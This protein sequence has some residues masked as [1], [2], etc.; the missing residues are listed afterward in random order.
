MG[1]CIAL[2]GGGAIRKSELIGVAEVCRLLGLSPSTV[3]NMDREGILPA[4]RF[5][6][7]Y[8]KWARKDVMA[9]ATGEESEDCERVVIIYCRVSHARQ[10]QLKESKN[11]DVSSDL[12]RQVERMKHEA[13]NRYPGL[14]Q[15]VLAEQGSGMNYER[16][17][18]NKFLDEV[19][20][21]KW[22]NSICLVENRERLV[23]F[24]APLVSKILS[25]KGIEL[26][27]T[28]QE[29]NTADQDFS[30]DI[31]ACIHY[32][33]TKYYSGRANAR[34][35]AHLSE[36]VIRIAKQRIELGIAVK[37]VA[38][39][40][41]LEGF[42][43]ESGGLLSYNILNKY[44]YQQMKQLSKTI[45]S[46]ESSAKVYKREFI[47]ETTGDYVLPVHRVY[48]HYAKWATEKGL[49]VVSKRLFGIE[50]PFAH[51]AWIKRDGRQWSSWR[52][53]TVKG[54]QFHEFSP[55]KAVLA[56][57]P[58]EYLL[59]YSRSVSPFRGSKLE[60]YRKYRA[61]AELDGA[62][63]MSRTIMVKTLRDVG[64]WNEKKA[65]NQQDYLLAK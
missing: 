51:K 34:N 30:A 21:G 10:A 60:F 52:G 64:W 61:F 22:D 14:R 8:R 23:R 3:R 19:L 17:I 9:Y 12:N 36:E 39:Q 56:E 1:D 63:P 4:Y 44:V 33:S 50:F 24:A 25:S 46:V 55:E 47:Q 41:N 38:D 59:R 40:M 27:Y 32:F 65:K 11:G 37:T 20:A 62:L 15:V 57:T 43:T 7:G 48:D 5:L 58:K 26:I 2:N 53:F 35:R 49:I 42:R 45:A 6:N 29:D 28:A 31:L 18:L 54:E 16:K 13:K